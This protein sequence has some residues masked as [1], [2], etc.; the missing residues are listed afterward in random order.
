MW[1]KLNTALDLKNLKTT[2]KHGGETII[3]K[4][5][6]LIQQ[7]K[8]NKCQKYIILEEG[9]NIDNETTSKLGCQ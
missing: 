1:R 9:L 5:H 2:L 7:K 8:K 3:E 6:Y 4:Y